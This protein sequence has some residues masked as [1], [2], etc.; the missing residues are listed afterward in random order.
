MCATTNCSLITKTSF[1]PSSSSYFEIVATAPIN[2]RVLFG[3]CQVQCTQSLPKSKVN[4]VEKFKEETNCKINSG[5]NENF[6]ILPQGKDRKGQLRQTEERWKWLDDGRGLIAA[7][8]LESEFGRTFKLS[9]IFEEP[10]IKDL[11]TN[12][13][14]SSRNPVNV[15]RR[16]RSDTHFTGI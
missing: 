3:F 4:T 10:Y 13:N 9:T 2:S 1:F 11:R 15:N 7:L 16:D 8:M 6:S 5:F 14:S 12:L